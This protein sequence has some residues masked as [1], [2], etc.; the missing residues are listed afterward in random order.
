M[1]YDVAFISVEDGKL[2]RELGEIS[3]EELLALR[4][5][6]KEQESE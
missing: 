1:T 3:R 5:K 4:A 2:V 6:E